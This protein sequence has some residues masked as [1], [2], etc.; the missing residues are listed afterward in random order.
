MVGT[1]SQ[2][3]ASPLWCKAVFALGTIPSWFDF[4][5]G[6]VCAKLCWDATKFRDR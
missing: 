4:L 1:A 5:V 6:V 2:K 3:E